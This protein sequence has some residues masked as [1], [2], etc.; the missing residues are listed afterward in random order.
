[1]LISPPF[2]PTPIA[3]ESDEDYVH[4]CMSG[5]SPG[6]GA[7]PVSFQMGWHGGL[8]LTAPQGPRGAEPVRAIADGKVVYKRARTLLSGGDAVDHPLYYDNGFTS[9]GCVII[10]HNTEIGMGALGQT[11]TLRFFSVYMHLHTIHQNVKLDLPIYR[12][13]E[14]GQAGHIAGVPDRMHFEII[15]DDDCVRAMLGRGIG[16]AL[17]ANGRTDA[18][19]GDTYFRVPGG[20]PV[21]A[22]NP[23]TTS[24]AYAV[25]TGSIP[26]TVAATAH[27]SLAQLKVLNGYG[28]RSDADFT[29]FIT[30]KA[31]AAG[32]AKNIKVPAPYAQAVAGLNTI[33]QLGTISAEIIVRLRYHRGQAEW[34][35]SLPD[36]RPLST[37]TPL[38]VPEPNAEYELYTTATKRYPACASAGYE[39]LRF[40]RVLGP[41]ALHADDAD[42][43]VA[44]H[45]HFRAMPC[46]LNTGAVVQGFVDLKTPGIGVYSDADMPPWQRWWQ[47]QDF[48]DRDSRC[49]ASGI[50]DLLD[51]NG[52]GT[53]TAAE[54]TTMLA[55]TDV[56]QWLKRALVKTPTEWEKS[57]IDR[58]WG[59]LMQ[60]NPKDYAPVLGQC[61]NPESFAKLKAYLE[62]LCFWENVSGDNFLEPVHWH[63]ETR[64]FIKHFRKC[65]WLSA[66][67]FAQCFP[68]RQLHLSGTN[69][70]V[71]TTSWTT[72]LRAAEQ[73]A[74]PFNRANRR[75]GISSSPRRLVHYLSHVIP[76]TG[77]LRQVREGDN[78]AGTYLRGQRYW[79][80]YG[81]GLIQLTWLKTYKAY[82]DFRRFPHTVSA[83]TYADLGWDPDELIALNDTTF[84]ASNCADSAG[85]FIASHGSMLRRIDNGIEQ[86]DAIAV[87]RCVNGN[88][89]VQK[90]NGLD[91]RLQSILFL[92]D[93]LLNNDAS[94]RMET[95]TFS[96]RRNSQRE[97]TGE[98]NTNGTPKLEFILRET[99]WTVEVPLD[100][101]RP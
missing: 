41:D 46:L 32:A 75:Y 80:Y 29:T 16:A 72:A 31:A 55:N 40:G 33:A 18:V 49:N 61:M 53:L 76:E 1:M 4:R 92:R 26:Q 86:E 8:H 10:E 81:R 27:A 100:K 71:S 59:W 63:F 52:D 14:I 101:Q 6:D 19:F 85:Y 58:R 7:F 30:Q 98:L 88:F 74:V 89:A 13:D 78:R 79:P 62:M 15:G 65:G 67:E 43:Q 42:P 24:R 84:N 94:A 68:R 11:T 44:R 93:V 95:M 35:A 54:A 21:Y 47:V 57:S 64:E 69:F 23:Q 39:L 82:G 28:E 2:L 77:S 60:D 87:S 97:P 37:T 51:A 70:V 20:T 36:G 99:P 12:K 45:V 9:D 48:Q 50:I 3:N 96:W 90:L 34:T 56:R 5:D 17:G 73:W 66:R 22:E 83:G 38:S 91:V 25:P